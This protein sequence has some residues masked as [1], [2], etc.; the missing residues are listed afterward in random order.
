M[1]MSWLLVADV[2][3]SFRLP[4]SASGQA[5]QFMLSVQSAQLVYERTAYYP[6]LRSLIRHITLAASRIES[7]DRL[8]YMA[9][10][11]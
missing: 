11:G 2:V 9:C 1:L 10:Q 8:H 4:A 3:V 7:S 6:I 5:L